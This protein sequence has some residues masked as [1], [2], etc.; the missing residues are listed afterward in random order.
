MAPVVSILTP[1]YRRPDLLGRALRSVLE[2]VTSERE[3]WEVIVSDDSNLA[4]NKEVFEEFRRQ[5]GGSAVYLAQPAPLGQ[6]A[7]FNAL[8]LVARGR[9]V[10]FLHDDDFLL[11]GA[12]NLLWRIATSTND[13]AIHKMGIHVVSLTGRVLRVEQPALDVVLRPQEALKRMLADSSYI[14]F[15]SVFTERSNYIECGS[16]DPQ[17]GYLADQALWFEMARRHGIHEH[18]CATVAYTVHESAGTTSMFTGEF[19]T[20]LERL[21]SMYAGQLPV[22][23]SERNTL[24]ARF[25]WKFCLAGFIR[26]MKSGHLRRAAGTQSM[27]AV[28]DARQLA[29]PLEWKP[30][31]L[32]ARLVG[33]VVTPR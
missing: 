19:M 18:S 17:W 3:A 9:F 4:E 33:R 23:E 15:P 1:T 29:C 5:W 16:F 24:R 14:R 30:L 22:A 6:Q 26:A 21:V 13:G 28:L 32:A 31:A 2:A 11:P 10:Q 25:L 27:V 20:N 7:N 8:L 12:G